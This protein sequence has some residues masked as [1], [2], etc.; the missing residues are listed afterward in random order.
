MLLASKSIGIFKPIP[1]VEFPERERYPIRIEFD[2]K[3]TSLTLA[4]TGGNAVLL[5][6]AFKPAKLIRLVLFNKDLFVEVDGDF[7]YKGAHFSQLVGSELSVEVKIL[8]LLDFGMFEKDVA[9]VVEM[10]EWDCSLKADME[11]NNPDGYE[12]DELAVLYNHHTSFYLK[13]LSLSLFLPDYADYNTV[14]QRNDG[15]GRLVKAAGIDIDSASFM[16]KTDLVSKAYTQPNQDHPKY[17][18][19]IGAEMIAFLVSVGFFDMYAMSQ[20]LCNDVFGSTPSDDCEEAEDYTEEMINTFFQQKKEKI[21]LL[22]KDGLRI[23]Y[24]QTFFLRTLTDFGNQTDAYEGLMYLLLGTFPGV[25]EKYSSGIV[26]Y[27]EAS[28]GF[29]GL[30]C[31]YHQYLFLMQLD[32]N[33]LMSD[34]D[35]NSHARRFERFTSMARCTKLCF[36]DAQEFMSHAIKA[37]DLDESDV[38]FS[39]G[40]KINARNREFIGPFCELK[41]DRKCKCE[42]TVNGE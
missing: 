31:I 13:L 33:L 19:R 38:L 7:V 21:V 12:G 17:R 24:L 29:G 40:T 11:V 28:K 35:G 36:V 14:I 30:A 5:K 26:L 18:F 39:Y 10:E 16:I 3:P 15:T 41:N 9:I 27:S 42:E 8:G 20:V 23:N 34:L 25:A 1:Q 32:L 22:E 2:D 6:D 4:I 37:F